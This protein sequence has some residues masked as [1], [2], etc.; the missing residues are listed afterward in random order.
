MDI[1]L[2]IYSLLQQ[3]IIPSLIC[4]HHLCTYTDLIEEVYRPKPGNAKCRVVHLF[5][6]NMKSLLE[7]FHQS[8]VFLQKGVLRTYLD[9]IPRYLRQHNSIPVTISSSFSVSRDNT[10]LTIFGGEEDESITTNSSGWIEL[11]VTQGLMEIQSLSD[12]SDIIEVTVTIT[13]DCRSYKKVPL[14]LVDPSS[15]PLS[16]GPR[17]LRLSK[18]QPMLLIYLSDENLKEELKKAA[19]DPM[20]S[21]EDLDV[22]EIEKRSSSGCHL[23]DFVINFHNIDLDYVLAPYE[24][25]ARRC[26]G[27]CSHSVLRYQGNIATNHAKILASAYA[28]RNRNTHTVSQQLKEPCCVPIRYDPMP[29]LTLYDYDE[30]NYAVYPAM[31]VSA[32]GC[33]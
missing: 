15:V 30:L 6:F 27:L 18:L 16:Q 21:G 19:A 10:T 29:L 28:L 26:T 8:N 11:N 23:E 1:A 9:V 32:C 17:R 13:V 5:R 20:H 25:N 3:C 14:T 12:L 33:R 2:T 24:Y 22:E 4:T 7:I 31:S